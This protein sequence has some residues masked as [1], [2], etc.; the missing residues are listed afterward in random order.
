MAAHRIAPRDFV[1]LLYHLG[2]DCPG[3]I[4]RVHRGAGPGRLDADYETLDELFQS[5]A[6]HRRLPDRLKDP[7]PMAGVQGKVAVARQADGRLALPKPGSG[8]PTTHVLK[9]PAFADQVQVEREHVAMDLM[10]QGVDHPV[11]LTEALRVEGVRG[12]LVERFDRLV[13]MVR[14]VGC[15]RRISVRRSDCT[16][17]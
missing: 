6:R 11:A 5:L 15:I 2:A 12:L 4:S 13:E 8:A 7:P 14:S 1:E 17:A 3:S 10:R 16:R 9:V